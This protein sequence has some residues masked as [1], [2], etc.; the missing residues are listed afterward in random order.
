MGMRVEPVENVCLDLVFASTITDPYAQFVREIL[1][2]YSLGHAHT[3]Q[4]F[5]IYSPLDLYE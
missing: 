4:Y 2:W 3:F 1:G 5:G